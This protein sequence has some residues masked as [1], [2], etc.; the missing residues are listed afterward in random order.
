MVFGTRWLMTRH[1]CCG[2]LNRSKSYRSFTLHFILWLD[3]F[4]NWLK[5]R[6]VVIFENGMYAHLIYRPFP[7][8]IWVYMSFQMLRF[9]QLMLI[10]S[11]AYP[12]CILNIRDCKHST[13]LIPYFHY[14]LY[15]QDLVW[16]FTR[17]AISCEHAIV[18]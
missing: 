18:R 15:I 13:Y 16:H 17:I 8:T 7:E 6:I 2:L 3:T 5:C 1:G 11:Q 9:I 10:P 4:L 12:F 14:F